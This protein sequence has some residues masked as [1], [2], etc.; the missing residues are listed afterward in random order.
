MTKTMSYDIKMSHTRYMYLMD[1]QVNIQKTFQVMNFVQI[2]ILCCEGFIDR[3]ER[4]ARF[5]KETEKQQQVQEEKKQAQLAARQKQ[6][7][8]EEAKKM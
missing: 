6:S 1:I 5:K 4:A 7:S 2:L 3:E 8:E